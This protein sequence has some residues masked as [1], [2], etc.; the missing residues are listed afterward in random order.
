MLYNKFIN[1]NA[2]LIVS[3]NV[4]LTDIVYY[5]KREIKTIYFTVTR[6]FL[7]YV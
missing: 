1:R 5:S 7:I 4:A 3:I 6:F 2:V